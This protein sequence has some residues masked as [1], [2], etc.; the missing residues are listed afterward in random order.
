MFL[1]QKFEL[2][3]GCF[4]TEFVTDAEKVNVLN[5]CTTADVTNMN[6][7]LQHYDDLSNLS[8][9]TSNNNTLNYQFNYSDDSA[10]EL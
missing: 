3:V 1:R 5:T 6:F 10:E 4:P 8:Y 7:V 2:D 9:L